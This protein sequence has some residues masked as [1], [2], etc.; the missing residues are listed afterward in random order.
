MG[1]MEHFF[2]DVEH[3]NKFQESVLGTAPN[4]DVP[5]KKLMYG[6][7]SSMFFRKTALQRKKNCS[8]YCK[9]N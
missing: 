4:K 5:V 1:Q 8:H 3:Y 2:A 7:T 6:R 9:A